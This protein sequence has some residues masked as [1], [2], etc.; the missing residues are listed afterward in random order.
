MADIH[1]ITTDTRTAVE[2]LNQDSQ[3]KGI[4][5]WLSP[6][7]PSTNLNDAIGKRHR[8]TGSW[9]LENSTFK[10]WNSGSRQHLW[11]HGFPGCGKVSFTP[12]GDFL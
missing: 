12:S 6:A 3:F 5:D 10:D 2:R 8:G 9:F 7:D 1:S 4:N 11:L